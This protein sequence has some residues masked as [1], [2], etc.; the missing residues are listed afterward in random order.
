[1]SVVEASSCHVDAAAIGQQPFARRPWLDRHGSPTSRPIGRTVDPQRHS[2]EAVHGDREDAVPAGCVDHLRMWRQTLSWISC[3]TERTLTS[4]LAELL[5]AVPR[6]R[7]DGWARWQPVAG[8]ASPDLAEQ[9]RVREQD[10][11][12][13]F[14]DLLVDL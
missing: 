14:A 11:P 3:G 5:P 1:V 8:L 13:G 12:Q 6:A 10:V 2:V 4:R 7:A 9:R